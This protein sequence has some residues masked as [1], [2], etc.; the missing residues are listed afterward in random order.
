[1]QSIF[2][3]LPDLLP[4]IFPYLQHMF[5]LWQL[6]FAAQSESMITSWFANFRSW[7]IDHASI[8][9]LKRAQI[10]LFVDAKTGWTVDGTVRDGARQ[11]CA[12]GRQSRTARRQIASPGNELLISFA[13]L[14]I[15]HNFLTASS[16]IRTKENHIWNDRMTQ[17]AVYHRNRELSSFRAADLYRACFCTIYL[18][19]V[20]QYE[21]VKSVKS[22]I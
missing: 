14:G 11:G 16:E 3:D 12:A 6:L 15:E 21:Y 7:L 18:C 20:K 10:V 5:L 19:N 2:K 22:K 1:M 13:L 9:H 17:R 8:I 4:N